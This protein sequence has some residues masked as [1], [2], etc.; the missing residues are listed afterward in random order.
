V[1][2]SADLLLHPVRLR[3]VQAF[4]GK[5]P[6]TTTQLAGELSDI[7]A[8]SLYRHVAR[9]VGAG[10]L[11]V[12][13]ER[14]VRGALERTYRLRLAAATLEPGDLAAMSAEDHRQAFM[15]FTAELIREFGRYLE[16][17]DIDFFR[18]SVSYRMAGLWLDDAE[19]AGLVRDLQRALQRRMVNAPGEGRRRRVIGYALLPGEKTA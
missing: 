7:P 12:V 1:V 15:A 14:K 2:D 10:V 19:N 18:D 9:L 8:A 6:L 4:A 5:R 11:E 17:G 3:I 16:G 13:S